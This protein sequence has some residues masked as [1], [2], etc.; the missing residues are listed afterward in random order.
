MSFKRNKDEYDS[1]F[2][3][4]SFVPKRARLGPELSVGPSARDPLHARPSSNSNRHGAPTFGC[5]GHGST[6]SSTLRYHQSSLS[7]YDRHKMLVNQ[8]LLYHPGAMQQLQRDTSKDRRD[9]DVVRE[10]HRFLWAASDAPQNWE[11]QLAKKYYDKLFKEYCI[12]DLSRYTSNQIGMRWRVGKEVE[13]GK[14]QFAC[15]A[16]GCDTAQGLRS[17]EMNFAYKE[18]SE[19]KNA[20]VKL[21]LCTDCSQKL[22]YC[23]KRKEAK[24]KKKKQKRKR[25]EGKSGDETSK[26]TEQSS[27]SDETSKESEKKE[28]SDAEDDI[29]KGPAKILDEKSRED[30]FE[31]YL[32]DLLL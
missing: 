4:D 8:Y 3:G 29:W 5:Y 17:W 20:L 18:R 16:R 28:D 14:G 27:G 13:S 10:N 6:L 7:A 19:D 23:K 31:D 25:S 1:A 26:A 9:I 30:E 2:E 24:R 22:N 21:R 12:C 32:A 11:Q 15:G